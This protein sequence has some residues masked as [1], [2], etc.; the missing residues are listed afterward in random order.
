M[1]LDAKQILIFV[2]GINKKHKGHYSFHKGVDLGPK[3]TINANIFAPNGTIWL[4]HGTF[5]EGAF[6]GKSIRVGH[7]VQ[8]VLN[9]GFGP[10]IELAVTSPEDGSVVS[11]PHVTVTGTINNPTGEETGV[12]VNGFVGTVRGTNFV[13]DHVPLK[14]GDNQLAVVAA[15]TVGNS[16]AETLTVTADITA[17]YI[18]IKAD[19]V[20]GIAP[21]QTKLRVYNS[22][23]LQDQEISFTGPAEV[24]IIEGDEYGLYLI[25]IPEPGLY[26]FT[27]EATDEESNLYTDAVKIVVFNEAEIRVVLEAKWDGMKEKLSVEDVSGALSFHHDVSKQKYESIYTLIKDKLQQIIE[28]MEDIELIYA[29]NH[30]A[31]YRIHRNHKVDEYTDEEVTVTYYIYFS[32]DQNGLWKIEKY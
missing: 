31:K 28:Q 11:K 5:A 22:F 32:K 1:D 30:K 9:S 2:N 3:S 17:P 18:E 14:T 16:V 20:E 10:R 26:E 24:Q 19:A 13:V 4:N 21:L 8:V 15:D 7:D 25:E 6:I 23:G 29:K 27:V 12:T